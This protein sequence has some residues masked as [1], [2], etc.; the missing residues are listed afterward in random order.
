MAE[1][2]RAKVNNVTLTLPNRYFYKKVR[3]EGLEP[4]KTLVTRYPTLGQDLKSRPFDQPRVL[5]HAEIQDNT[6][7]KNLTPTSNNENKKSKRKMNP[8]G[9]YDYAAGAS[10]C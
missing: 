9:S 5:P 2:T 6:P 7:I 1:R 8:N 3:E 10:C 4:T